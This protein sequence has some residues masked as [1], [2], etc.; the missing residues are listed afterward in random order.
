MTDIQER[1]R[2]I[3][4]DPIGCGLVRQWHVNPDGPEAADFIDTLLKRIE[5]LEELLRRVE[6][7]LDAIICYAS[8]MGEHEPNRIAFDVRAALDEGT[9]R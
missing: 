3:H 9:E 8:T 7:H 6:P 5:M 1:L 4:S 2:A